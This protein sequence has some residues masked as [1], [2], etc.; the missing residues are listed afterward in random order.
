MKNYVLLILG[1]L[2]AV[3]VLNS[4][5]CGGSPPKQSTMSISVL[6]DRTDNLNLDPEKE[7]IYSLF[8]LNTKS[9]TEVEA[10]VSIRVS[11]ISSV[12]FNHNTDIKIPPV[13]FHSINIKARQKEIARFY[14]QLDQAFKHSEKKPEGNSS[15]FVPIAR[16][17]NRITKSDAQQKLLIVYSDLAEHSSWLNS[18]REYKKP[19]EILTKKFKDQIDLV[20]LS[21]VKLIIRYIPRNTEDNER[22]NRLVNVYTKL[23][24]EKGAT[25]TFEF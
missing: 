25:V 24:E 2:A 10:G 17:A 11:E 18:Y 4:L 22:F 6:I 12:D 21:G 14:E 15:I 7:L 8:H 13:D 5:S 3:L 23:F 16:E 20:D 19:T 1:L 9:L